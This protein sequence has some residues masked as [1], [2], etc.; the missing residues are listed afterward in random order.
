MLCLPRPTCTT[1]PEVSPLSLF[2]LKLLCPYYA[3]VARELAPVNFGLR[4]IGISKVEG[5]VVCVAIGWYGRGGR[6]D[7]LQR[8][9][10]Q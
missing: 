8:H 5:G 1:T 10:S 6:Q 3:Y 9:G 7:E 4:V 2:S